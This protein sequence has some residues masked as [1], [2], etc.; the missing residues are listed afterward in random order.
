MDTESTPP[1]EHPDSVRTA[2]AEVVSVT[3]SSVQYLLYIVEF[4]ITQGPSTGQ[5]VR[6]L[7][8][9]YGD[10]AIT[11]GKGEDWWRD[12]VYEKS[13]YKGDDSFVISYRPRERGYHKRFEAMEL[14]SVAPERKNAGRQDTAGDADEPR[15]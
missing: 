3:A 8:D 6:C 1:G 4:K 5:L 10:Q 12:F 2:V 13:G 11:L 9:G 15:R 14:A 7:V